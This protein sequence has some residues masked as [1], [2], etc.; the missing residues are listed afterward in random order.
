MQVG[1]AA[2]DSWREVVEDLEQQAA[3]LH[4]RE[5][6][7]EVDQLGQAEYAEV[8]LVARLHG[9]VDA[10]VRLTLVDGLRV[11][12]VLVSAGADHCVVED[13]HGRWLV[14]SAA[15]ARVQGLSPRAV[16]EPARRVVARLRLSSLLR[17]L[18]EDAA[19]V[20]VH[21]AGGDRLEGTV[22]RV[23]RDFFELAGAGWG[24]EVVGVGAV[25]A[26]R[27]AR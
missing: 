11:E 20:R 5:R 12:G 26:V 2:G 24:L 7:D 22:G 1:R 18:A 9:S 4:L 3:G 13:A 8:E 17:R 27:T 16:S 14:R 15:V 10:P 25:T 23:G 21:L 19:P 6:D